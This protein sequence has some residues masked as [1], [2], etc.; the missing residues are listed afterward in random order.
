MGS[1]VEPMG[2][3]QD[4]LIDDTLRVWQPRT[5]RRLTREDARQI[6]ENTV[7][8]FRI[9]QEWAAKD[10]EVDGRPVRRS[11][12]ARAPRPYDREMERRR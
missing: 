12:A 11:P 3:S 2:D 6:A 10:L 4:N 1:S 9:I 5:A 7:G 8:F